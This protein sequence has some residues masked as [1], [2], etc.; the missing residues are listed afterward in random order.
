MNKLIKILE[1]I[2]I[3]TIM[4]LIMCAIIG[5]VGLLAVP[6]ATI[7]C[8]GIWILCD[9]IGEWVILGVAIGIG[10]LYFARQYMN[11]YH[12]R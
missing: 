5:L 6:F 4:L 2:G 1:S 9:I 8:V 10:V 11:V 7:F 3:A 12:R